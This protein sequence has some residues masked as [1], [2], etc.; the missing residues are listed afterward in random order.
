MSTRTDSQYASL[1]AQSQNDS[2]S[3]PT[4]FDVIAQENMHQLFRRA[5]NHLF[6][7]LADSLHTRSA[8]FQKIFKYQD[9]IYLSLHSFIEFLYLKAYDGLFSETFY[10]LKRIN[11]NTNFKRVLS[12]VCSVIIPYLKAKLDEMYE[13]LERLVDE[14]QLAPEENRFKRVFNAIILRFY[15]IFNLIWHSVFWL[16][17]FKFIINASPFNSPLLRIL[18]LKL[19]YDTNKETTDNVIFLHQILKKSNNIFTGFIYFLQFYQWY[20]TYNENASFNPSSQQVSLAKILFRNEARNSH[21]QYF[22]ATEST[23]KISQILGL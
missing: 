5:F 4:I 1:L 7:W 14:P 6:K 3:K 18:N 17:R 20:E 10:G 23:R 8:F 15:P 2:A 9:G 21:P 12:I 16:F 13:E 22:T 11:L 19:V